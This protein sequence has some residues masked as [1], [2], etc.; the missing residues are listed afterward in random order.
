VGES[1]GSRLASGKSFQ[2]KKKKKPDG[3]LGEKIKFPKK[4]QRSKEKKTG[5]GA[6]RK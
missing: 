1:G 6:R 4:K 5:K 3:G 2:R